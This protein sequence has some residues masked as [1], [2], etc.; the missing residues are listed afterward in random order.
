MS[1]FQKYVETPLMKQ[2]YNIKTKHP[3]AILLFRV[4][5]F[6]ETFG[7]D[8]IRTSEILGI[9]LTRRANGS[10]QF[11]ELAG[12]PY[13]ALDTYLPRL[14]R[15]GQRV[16]ICEQLEDPKLTKKIVKRGIIEMVTPGVS[17]NENVLNHKENNFL[18]AVHIDKKIAGVA[19]LDIST[20]EFLTSEGTIE[21]IDQM[22]NNFQPKEVL[23]EKGR[24]DLFLEYFGQKY[25]TYKLDDWIFTLD[26]ANDRLIKQFETSSLK[27]F[28]VQNLNFG[29][30]AAGAILYYL[31]I[32]QHEQLGHIT[33]LSRIEESRYVWLDKFTVKNL[34]LFHSPYEGARTLIDVMD[35]TI[36]PMG[37]RLM[38]R[39]LSLPL[40]DIQPVNE[41]LDVVQYFVE[42]VG[43]KEEISGLIRQIGDLER[44][45]S[46]VAVS[47]IN[48][49]EVVQLMR[50]LKAID[51]LRDLCNRSG[52]MPL[53]QIAEQLNPCKSI[54]DKIA[55]E[56][57]VDPPVQINKGN[58][59]ASG[60]SDELDDLRKILYNGKDYIT[61][62][63][64]RESIRTGITSLKVS[65]N[66]VFGYYIEVRNT[67][68]DKVPPEWIR[69]QTLVSAE[70]YITEELKEYES[71]IL[72][73]EEKIITLE[74]KLFTDL[75]LSI[76]EYIPPIQLNSSLIARLD[77]LQSFA[78]I[79]LENNYI[80]PLL[81]DSRLLNISEG[82]HPVIEKQL[83][84]GESYVP[85]DLVLDPE[86]QQIIILTGPNMSGKSALL[87]QT[88]LI[89]L[90]AQTGCFV[91]AKSAS[92]GM[93]DKIFTRV[94]ASDNI[95]LGEST[96]MVE[97]NETASIL[98]NLS[99]RS[100]ILLDEIG[101][102]TST[103]DGI[104][105]AWAIVEY[106]HENKLRAKTLFA[107]HYHELNEMESSFS[108]VKNYS[109]SI[110]ELNNKVIFLRK[111]KRGGSEHS[112][113]IH[114]ARMAGMPRS[115][116]TRADEILKE[117][118]Q[119]HDKK[120]LAKPISDIAGHR[121][122]M[123]LSFFQLDDPV[124]KQIRDEILEIDIDNLTPV[125]ALNKLYNIKKL[126]K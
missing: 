34:E 113:G 111:L 71:K 110:K 5:D 125:E 74:T 76:L 78:T 80:R 66:N 104:S 10:A 13:H 6:Y 65:F 45:I 46:K 107:T 88:A 90:M 16:A 68:K 123:Q 86:D 19:F 99:D 57:N 39:W 11:V 77:C 51:P 102:G 75:V 124:L 1:D 101:R 100:L 73:A 109:V 83:P 15:A 3:D 119:G 33:C 108:R 40:K 61:D 93:V 37:G 62:L 64:N 2:Y 7:E 91:P 21:Y 28:G 84:V 32:T 81:D 25:Y 126:L 42:N 50:A 72:G 12:F 49:R 47:R 60:I 96:F 85:N 43:S 112:F 58:V 31:D 52:C 94:G 4:G 79:S 36:S 63:Q 23:F 82:R 115:V 8:A 105:I 92:I 44:L 22:L 20:G 56:I 48:P 121:E 30:I 14:V 116:V 41:R 89:V 97:M 69:K 118:E 120:E 98:N 29:I 103:Y 70:R 117:L 122:G 38:K 55:K 35:R 54:S 114:V 17:L 95:S 59:I 87:R 18:A 67:H 24:K 27:G 26:A 53:V 106:L 9:T